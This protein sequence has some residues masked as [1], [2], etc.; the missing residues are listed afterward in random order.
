[1]TQIDAL[2]IL[3]TG[4]NVFLT[5]EPGAG[6][7]Y[8][9]NEYVAYLRARDIEPAITASTGIAATH[10]GG[11]TIHSWSGIGI[12]S[13]LSKYDLDK[14]AT[15][16]YVHKRISRTKVLI[17]D[18]VSMLPAHTLVMIDAVCRTIKQNPEPFGG[19]QIILVG[20]FFQLPPIERPQESNQAQLIQEDK[21]RFAY[22]SDAW[23]KLSPIVCYL[24]EQH[25][26]DDAEFLG[27]LSAMRRGKIEKN[28]MDYLHART[29]EM[30]EYPENITKLF[31][32]NSNVD[33]VNTNMLYQIDGE[34]KSY[35][36]VSTGVPALVATLQRGCMSPEV[37]LLKEGAVV[38]CTK[39]NPKERY[40]NGTLGVVESFD[41]STNNPI[42]RTLDNRLITLEPME[43]AVEENGRIKA[44]IIQL[45]LR[46][47]WAITIHKSQGMSLD[48]AVMDLRE[49]FEYGQGYVALS[50]VRRLSGLYL[51]GMNDRALQVHPDILKKDVVFHED[52]EKAEAAF[53]KLPTEDLEKMHKNFVLAL[54][55][56]WK[57]PKVK[58]ALPKKTKEE[59][60]LEKIRA[61]HKNAYRP[62]TLLDDQRLTEEF[63]KGF[64][65]AK[66]CES[67]GRQRGGIRAR[68]IKLGLIE[69]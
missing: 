12:K 21:V 63:L 44:K 53:K 17:I 55:G 67:F 20:D 50:R 22:E 13:F 62:W 59:G 43:W 35:K 3:K 30:D 39:N 27:T 42:I 25:R 68:L 54:G 34:S 64:S 58:D 18:E 24:T 11:M 7:S 65:V 26:Q 66:L 23:K 60:K 47:A 8:T 49:V 51:L 69:E 4:A 15:S 2:N 61:A 38:M 48:A 56:K 14:I 29:I 5:G 16:E 6:K 33:H 45:P 28:H 9:I 1:M 57:D 36:M 10:I 19:I 37:L 32:H 31:S 52:S 40:A 46:L 41:P